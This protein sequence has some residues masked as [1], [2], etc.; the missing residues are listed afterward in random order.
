MTDLDK[1]SLSTAATETAPQS[2]RQRAE[3]TFDKSVTPLLEPIEALPPAAIRQMFHELR[4][5]QIELEMQN[6]EMRRAQ[7]ELAVSRAR[8]F[9]LYD[10]APVGYLTVNAAGMISQANLTAVTLLGETRETLIKRAF[11]GFIFDQDQDLYYLNLKQLVEGGGLLTW[12]SRVLKKDG[13]SFWALLRASTVRDANGALELRIALTDIS[14]RK[15]AELELK[16]S[17][18]YNR[19]LFSDSVTPKVVF[20]AENGR[21]TDCNAAAVRVYGYQTRD[22]VIGMTPLDVSDATQYDGSESALA[23]HQK[24]R[25]CMENGSVFFPWRHRRPDG[26]IW[27]AELSLM[28]LQH[29]GKVLILCQLQDI[30]ERRAAQNELR[31]LAQA[32]E[33]SPESI[34]ITDIKGNIEYVNLKFRVSFSDKNNEKCLC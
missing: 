23:A 13:A 24:I 1:P 33:Q 15:Q 7:A 6:E 22:E 26:Q 11:S 3:A 31:K 27:D 32:L 30:T 12:E 17:E 10:L 21:Y 4:V 16:A 19:I 34:V 28:R 14:V 2:L 9:D 5:H 8:Y 29:D 25:A 20:D 18:A